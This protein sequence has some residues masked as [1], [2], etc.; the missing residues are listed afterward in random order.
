MYRKNSFFELLLH[1]TIHLW[2]IILFI[3]SLDVA[4][5]EQEVTI[6]WVKRILT[7]SPFILA[8]STGKSLLSKNYTLLQY[9]NSCS[10]Q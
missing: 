10:N 6:S 7:N 1:V 2:L 9:P 4:V 5:N 3:F 8:I